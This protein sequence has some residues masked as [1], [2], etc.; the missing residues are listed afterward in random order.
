[1]IQELNELAC[2]KQLA[3][4]LE[5]HEHPVLSVAIIIMVMP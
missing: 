2:I 3:Q 4:F 1:M 5:L